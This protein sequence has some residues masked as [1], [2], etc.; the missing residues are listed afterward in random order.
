M[1]RDVARRALAASMLAALAGCAYQDPLE[2]PDLG[3]PMRSSEPQALY[4]PY[5]GFGYSYGYGPGYRGGYDPYYNPYYGG[6][7]PRYYGPGVIY[8]PYPR[9]VPV[10][11]AD[12]NNDGRCDKRPHRDGNDEDGDGRHHGPNDGKDDNRDG[13]KH[14]G[15]PRWPGS[16]DPDGAKGD[17]PRLRRDD[18][19]NRAGV[20]GMAPRV[21]PVPAVVQPATRPVPPAPRPPQA[22]PPESQRRA[23]PPPPTDGGPRPAPVRPPAAA[24]DG[25]PPRR[26]D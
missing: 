20:P 3:P 14:D 25:S 23:V 5:Y 12:A 9:Y 18:G 4:D 21:A 1:K 6:A 8:V 13:G 2:L 19:G 7:D 22:R 10:P 24:D 15:I 11:C 16:R 26:P 17:G